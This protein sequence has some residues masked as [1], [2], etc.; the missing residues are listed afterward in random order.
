MIWVLVVAAAIIGCS[1]SPRPVAASCADACTR[2]VALGCD[3]TTPR[4]A[5]CAEWLCS[6]GGTEAQAAC[7]VAA[8][9]CA[10]AERCR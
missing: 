5:T 6:A 10:E 3:A 1:P 8:T 2:L 7:V 4:G 9:T